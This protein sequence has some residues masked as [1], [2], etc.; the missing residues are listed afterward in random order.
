MSVHPSFAAPGASITGV[1]LDGLNF[2]SAAKVQFDG[3]QNG[4]TT[5]PGGSSG[6]TADLDASLLT[7]GMHKISVADPSQTPGVSKELLFSVYSPTPVLVRLSPASLP[8]GGSSFTMAVT[9]R[10]F[11]CNGGISDSVLYFGLTRHKREACG[12]SPT[13]GGDMEMTVTIDSSEITTTGPVTVTVVNPPPGGGTSL[14]T[15]FTVTA[16]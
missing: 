8:A 9:G 16:Q 10:N 15:L 6:M 7:P 2:T 1:T 3:K 13:S 5:H 12:P 14:R 4:A 11:I